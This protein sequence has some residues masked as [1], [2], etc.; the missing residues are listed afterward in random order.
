MGRAACHIATCTKHIHLDD[1]AHA[2][3]V[4][5][6]FAPGVAVAD[7]PSDLSVLAIIDCPW[8][9]NV[10][11]REIERGGGGAERGVKR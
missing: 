5:F 2:L 1:F 6:S 8:R 9:E 10:C 11:E 3:Y 7:E 4:L